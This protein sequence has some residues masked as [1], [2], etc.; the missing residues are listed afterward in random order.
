MIKC[1]NPVKKIVFAILSSPRDSNST[2]I[3]PELKLWAII[4]D[5]CLTFL[6]WQ[7]LEAKF[8]QP[9]FELA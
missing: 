2:T 6:D 5:A 7:A 1:F 3:Y 8:A 4:E 9:L